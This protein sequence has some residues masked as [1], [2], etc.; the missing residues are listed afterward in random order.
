[1]PWLRMKGRGRKVWDA[2]ELG[3]G[4]QGRVG[5]ETKSVIW[6]VQPVAPN[7]VLLFSSTSTQC[8]WLAL[9]YIFCWRLLYCSLACPAVYLSSRRTQKSSCLCTLCCEQTLTSYTALKLI[10]TITSESP[11][12][13][14]RSNR[15]GIGVHLE[16]RS[17][18]QGCGIDVI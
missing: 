9:L 4:Y 1:M 15:F 7:D 11:T 13:V 6:S 2:N 12:R 18:L 8:P 3:S 14:V 17:F 5:R 16:G 10:R